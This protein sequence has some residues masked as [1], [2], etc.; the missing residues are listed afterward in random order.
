MINWLHACSSDHTELVG[1]FQGPFLYQWD[2][3]PL[4]AR[5]EGRAPYKHRTRSAE[6]CVVAAAKATTTRATLT[7]DEKRANRLSKLR[8]DPQLLSIPA[9][10]KYLKI[11]VL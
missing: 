2:L 8:A 9:N 4:F 10:I 3:Y 11:K 1:H 7:K 5:W 6:S